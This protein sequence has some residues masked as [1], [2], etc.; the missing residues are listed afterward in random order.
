MKKIVLGILLFVSPAAVLAEG[1]CPADNCHAQQASLWRA[2]ATQARQA[3]LQAAQTL[4]KTDLIDVRPMYRQAVVEAVRN[5]APQAKYIASLAET[6]S[7]RYWLKSEKLAHTYLD[8][9]YYIETEEQG[10]AQF[11]DVKVTVQDRKHVAAVQVTAYNYDTN[12]AFDKDMIAT[13]RLGLRYLGKQLY[14]LTDLDGI[15]TQ[16]RALAQYYPLVLVHDF[17]NCLIKKR[18]SSHLDASVEM[19]LRNGINLQVPLQIHSPFVGLPVPAFDYLVS[20]E[21]GPAPLFVTSN[22]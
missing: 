1:V 18:D 7:V 3:Q 15:Q 6:A 20:I 5:A 9:Y 11:Y 14:L 12:I 4:P 8:V 22:K 21:K 17:K 13:Y 10:L 16:M 2:V 19:V